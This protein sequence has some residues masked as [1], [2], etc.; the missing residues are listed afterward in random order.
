M[1]NQTE[2]N[3]ESV[4]KTVPVNFVVNAVVIQYCV[5]YEIY[6]NSLYV[7]G[8]SK[9]DFILFMYLTLTKKATALKN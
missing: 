6:W 9:L 3:L 1:I 2:R 4:L 8:C 7:M 5:Y